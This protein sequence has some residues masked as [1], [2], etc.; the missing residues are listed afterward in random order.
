MSAIDETATGAGGDASGGE[1]ARR[2]PSLP[3]LPADREGPT[4]Q[5]TGVTDDDFAAAVAA[6]LDRLQTRLAETS[7]GVSRFALRE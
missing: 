1:S 7:N 5:P 3:E 2:P 4:E 6:A